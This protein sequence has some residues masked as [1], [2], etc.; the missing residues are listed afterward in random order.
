[1][2]CVL[3]YSKGIKEIVI[4]NNIFESYDYCFKLF[5]KGIKTLYE[6]IYEK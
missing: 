5:L 1:M 2:I 3:V 6:I 4:Y